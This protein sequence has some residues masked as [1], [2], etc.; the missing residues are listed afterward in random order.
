MQILSMTIVVGLVLVGC[1]GGGSGS[2]GDA[3]EHNCDCS[4]EAGQVNEADRSA[5]EAQCAAASG[6]QASACYECISDAS[7]AAL[8]DDTICSE[9][10]DAG[11]GLNL[12]SRM[13]HDRYAS[14]GY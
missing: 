7:C 11:N 9:V 13:S 5:C 2:V 1:G 8:Q 3:C 6:G 14:L 10:C 4:I 12:T